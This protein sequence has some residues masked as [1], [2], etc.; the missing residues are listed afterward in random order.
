MV[1]SYTV[2]L[3]ALSL[4]I[5]ILASF[6]ALD[7]AGRVYA[8]LQQR[9]LWLVGGA[10]A[11]GTG[12]WSMH[13][14]AMLALHLPIPVSY[15]V[16]PTLL[17]LLYA[18]VASGIA[19]WLLSRSAVQP[20][21]LLGGS[22]CMGIAIA[23][24][25]YTG[26]SAMRMSAVIQYD[27]SL[28]S[29]SVAIAITASMAS[30][31]LAFRLQHVS[32]QTLFGQKL[33]SAVV[34]GLAIS[35]MHYTGMAATHFLPSQTP[36]ST[37]VYTLDPGFLAIAIGIATLLILTLALLTSLFDQRLTLQ[38]NRQ[39]SLQ[40]SENRF[41]SLIRDMP[42]GVLLLNANAVILIC[43][44]IAAD[45]LNLKEDYQ[46]LVFSEVATWLNVDGT[47]FPVAE[48]P[49]QQAIASRQP[50]NNVILG[51]RHPVLSELRWFLVHAAPQCA[52]DGTVEQVVCTFSDITSQKQAEVALRQ[53]ADRERTL[54]RVIQRMRQTL[55]LEQIFN[56]TTQELRQ[57]LN[58]DRVGVYRFKPNW[59]GE[60][61]SE[62]LADGCQPLLQA[63]Y[64]ESALTKVA[65]DEPKCV[66]KTLNSQD[67]LV[68]DTYLQDTQGG[69]Y[70]QGVSYRCV[71]DIYA[72]GFTPCYIELLERF[73]TRAYIIVPIF[74]GKQ[75][76]GLLAAYQNTKPREWDDAEIKMV[77]QIGS[78]LGVAIQQ[79]E[80]LAQTQQQ[81]AELQKAKEAADVANRAKSEFLANMSHELRTPLN[82][83]LGFAQLM[84]R[85][86]ELATKHQEFTSIISRS[87]EHLLGL[88][89]DILDMSKIEAGKAT[90]AETDFDLTY[91]LDSLKDMLQL[92][93]ISK[94]LQLIFECDPQVPQFIHTDDNKLRQVLI[95]L[96]GNAIKFTS[97]GHVTLQVC[98]APDSP[99]LHRGLDSSVLPLNFQ[100]IDTGSGIDPN[101]MDKLFSAFGQTK[102]GMKSDQ[103]TG[104]GLPISQKFVQLMG[105]KI[106]VEST[107]GQGSIFQ[108]TICVRPA[109]KTQAKPSPAKGLRVIGLAPHQP[110]YRILVV[111]DNPTNRLLLTKLLQPLGFDVYEAVNGAEAIALWQTCHPHLIWMDMRMPVMDGY[112]ATRQIKQQDLDQQT[113]IIALTASAFEEQR[114]T[115]L[116]AG[117]DDFVRKPFQATELLDKISQYLGVEYLYEEIAPLVAPGISNQANEDWVEPTAAI[118]TGRDRLTSLSLQVM[119]QTWLQQ[120][121]RAALQGS[122]SLVLELAQDI[123]QDQQALKIAL[124]NL[125]ENF[126]FEQIMTL[127]QEA[128]NMV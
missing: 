84:S 114:Q 90:L 44:Q 28:L 27:V 95:N 91:L 67:S 115:I 92:K 40:V 42:V 16:L 47:P 78:Q 13:F 83:I 25:H 36:A 85:D 68:Q 49:V 19:L 71:P 38:L 9:W 97:Q 10:V 33:I 124:I 51:L 34:M 99:A 119:P 23:G 101:E 22:L 94:G 74:C 30:L 112:E 106:T 5:A 108:F 17:S 64:Y 37:P 113:V 59:S 52:D 57:A 32:P 76:W 103:G 18:I 100:I 120:L 122:D 60:F 109:T 41:R 80:L 54:I 46:H 53:M 82:A 45:L 87:G 98:L 24:M 88:I 126:Q 69:M 7:L 65:V 93:A 50:V 63:Q 118:V 104:L 2:S 58:C 75:L 3:V 110:N 105:G 1:G 66:V 61:V 127:S 102:T 107:L 96:L 73:Q 29:L 11:M 48:L 81:S 4:M 116:A 128:V 43:N 89:N 35:G 70:R 12:I 39:Q 72:A 21:W 14:V 77:T 8:A 55:D 117:C 111:E 79:A 125:A 6:T 31:W 56:T 62:S 15:Q 20:L 123:P 121:H 86:P 26:M